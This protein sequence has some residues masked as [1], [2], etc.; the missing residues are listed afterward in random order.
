MT[1]VSGLLDFL[2][3]E[4][5]SVREITNEQRT[6]SMRSNYSNFASMSASFTP[7]FYSDGSVTLRLKQLLHNLAAFEADCDDPAVWIQLTNAAISGAQLSVLLWYSVD[8]KIRPQ[9][10]VELTSYPVT[11]SCYHY[12]AEA[13]TSLPLYSNQEQ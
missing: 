7:A 4:F 9:A 3:S 13:M 10:E 1:S 12:T 2:E 11:A 5:S 8:T 6:S